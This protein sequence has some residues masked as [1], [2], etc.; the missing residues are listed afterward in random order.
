MCLNIVT[1]KFKN[2]DDIRVG[3]KVFSKHNGVYF[4]QI[5]NP[6]EPRVM[7]KMYCSG[8]KD[9]WSLDTICASS[10]HRYDSGFHIWS[11]IEAA[12]ED[13]SITPDCIVEVIAWDI[14]AVGTNK[15]TTHLRPRPCFVAK[16]IRLMRE[17]NWEVKNVS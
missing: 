12:E 16:N 17:M 13:Y 8:V 10:F 6:H 2:N 11:T 14:R 1:E 7:G 4:S 9:Y 3:Y 15:T 5:Y